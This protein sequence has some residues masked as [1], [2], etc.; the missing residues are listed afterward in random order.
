LRAFQIF[1]DHHPVGGRML[2][3]QQERLGEIGDLCDAL[4][5]ARTAA[6][7]RLDDKIVPALDGDALQG[8]RR[9][10]S[11]KPWNG[12]ARIR[13]TPFHRQLVASCFGC[14]DRQTRQAQTLANRGCGDRRIGRHADHTVDAADLAAIAFGGG[15]G[16]GCAIDIGDQT[17]IGKGKARRFG[18][19]VRDHDVIA[20]LLGPARR[21]RGFDAA[22]N[23][24]H[25]FHQKYSPPFTFSVCAVM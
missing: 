14:G 4:H 24:Q 2:A 18:I 11:G 23:D 25:R 1:L 21:V 19:A 15:G 6:V 9:F 13:E 7:H 12:H 17:G 8:L 16:F 20:K 3:R 5:A 10:H 22:R